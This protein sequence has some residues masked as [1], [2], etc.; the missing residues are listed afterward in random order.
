MLSLQLAFDTIKDDLQRYDDRAIESF[1]SASAEEIVRVID[2][3]PGSKLSDVIKRVLT[4]PQNPSNPSWRRAADNMQKA[5][6][7]LA[8]RSP[9]NADRISNW[10]G[11]KAVPAPRGSA[12]E[13]SQGLSGG[14]D[15]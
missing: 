4:L 15:G 8:A 7:I 5:C 1:A 13:A 3:S 2:A 12:L 11:I 14:E 9:L 6:E 10:T